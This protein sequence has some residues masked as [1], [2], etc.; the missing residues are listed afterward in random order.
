[1]EI[2][3]KR[4]AK[5]DKYT[6]GKV[7][8]DGVKICDSIEDKDRGLTQNMSLEEINRIKIKHQTAI[9]SGVYD[10]TMKVKSTSFSKKNYYKQ[11]CNGYL[12]R[13]LNVKG[14]EGILLHK[15]TDQDSSS[16]CI[17][18]GYNTIVGKVTNTQKAFETVYAM[19]K[20]ASSKGEKITLTIK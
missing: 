20:K 11:Y 3:I 7:Y 18:L 16:G 12:P 19:L 17:I 14:F 5:R 1:M 9:P 10:V 6:I 2:L 15:G 13:L 4:I 8:I